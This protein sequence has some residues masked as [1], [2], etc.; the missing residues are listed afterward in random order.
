MGSFFTN[1]EGLG[2]MLTATQ[3]TGKIGTH[4]QT[5]QCGDL[6]L[7]PHLGHY[8]LRSRKWTHYIVRPFKSYH[9]G[10]RIASSKS[11]CLLHC[12]R[13][14]KTGLFSSLTLSA[15]RHKTSECL[16]GVSWNSDAVSLLN[17]PLSQRR[18]TIQ[19]L[20]CSTFFLNPRSLEGPLS[21]EGLLCFSC[22]NITVTYLTLKA[23]PTQPHSW[24]PLEINVRSPPPPQKKKKKS[25][26]FV[27]RVIGNGTCEKPYYV[28]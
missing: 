1:E 25:S 5:F 4:I 18:G 27:K 16:K 6:E 22:H 7:F 26:G 28:M 21:S 19:A 3:M 12:K 9:A 23:Q 13:V 8:F 24:I 11:S 17:T 10:R 15:V 14:H 2:V 20:Y